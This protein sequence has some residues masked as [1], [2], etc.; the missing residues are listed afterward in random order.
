MIPSQVFNGLIG[1]KLWVD[2]AS[3]NSLEGT[4]LESWEDYIVLR[5]G[6]PTGPQIYTVA[7]HHIESFRQ[8]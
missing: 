7:R 8:A 4:L 2:L 1:Q 3:G 5:C 6:S